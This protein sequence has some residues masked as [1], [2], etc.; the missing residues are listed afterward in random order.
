MRKTRILLAGI[1]IAAAFFL[2]SFSG[3]VFP[4]G[5]VKA[6]QDSVSADKDRPAGEEGARPGTAAVDQK[7]IPADENRGMDVE[8]QH[9]LNSDQAISEVIG[10]KIDKGKVWLLVEK[11]KYRLTVY[12]DDKPVKSYP[13]V[14][15]PNPVGPKIVAGDGRTP[16]G[17]FT[18][19]EL[20]PHPEWSKFLWLD[21]P[22][23]ESWR[24]YTEAMAAGRISPDAAIGGQ[25]G[26]HGVPAGQ[27]YLVRNRSNWTLGCV[28][29]TT[30]DINEL[31]RVVQRG[32]RVVIVP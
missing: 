9:P 20:Y 31:Y 14:F 27:D 1:L 6:P 26:I 7:D 11:A 8:G 19:R 4:V 25:V 23:E 22:N 3:E 13:V 10:T 21:Y 29:L 16:E 30:S 12:Y 32:T 5:L 24:N 18:I 15:G 28:S 2:N 17:E